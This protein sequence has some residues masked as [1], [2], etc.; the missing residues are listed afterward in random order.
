MPSYFNLFLKGFKRKYFLDQSIFFPDIKIDV[1]V[2][3]PGG[4]G[5]ATLNNYLEK[6]CISNNYLKKN[7]IDKHALMHI[8]RPLSS[9]KKIK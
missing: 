2:C 4:C 9:M 5:N 7:S 3:S 8:P 6:Y 1:I